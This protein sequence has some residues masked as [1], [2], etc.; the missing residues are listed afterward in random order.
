MLIQIQMIVGRHGAC[1][2]RYNYTIRFYLKSL[3]CS[4]PRGNFDPGGN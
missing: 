4:D 3:I 1:E 2:L